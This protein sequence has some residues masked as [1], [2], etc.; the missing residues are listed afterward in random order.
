MDNFLLLEYNLLASKILN[1]GL[2][3]SKDINSI[4]QHNINRKEV[5][6]YIRYYGNH[7]ELLKVCTNLD[8]YVVLN[9]HNTFAQTCKWNGL[10]VVKWMLGLERGFNFIEG[11][12][13]ACKSNHPDIA[14]EVYNHIANKENLSGNLSGLFVYACCNNYMNIAKILFVVSYQCSCYDS[15]YVHLNDM[16]L[17]ACEY[18]YLEMVK[19]LYSLGRI[20]IHIHDEYAFRTVCTNGYLELAKWLF[21]IS[22][23]FPERTRINMIA[24]GGQA[25][26]HACANG[27]LE[28]IKWLHGKVQLER[29]M[30]TEALD[31]AKEFGHED[32]VQFLKRYTCM[33]CYEHYDHDFDSLDSFEQVTMEWPIHSYD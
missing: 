14:I 10:D 11:F 22:T 18:G 20:N 25:F 32:V 3:S 8:N 12:I 31:W 29:Y 1:F 15:I 19:W 16:F 13:E 27:H 4:V 2:S 26:R 6:K 28:I 23:H 7:E 5:A 33:Y 30:V 9:C 24:R 21:D 17:K